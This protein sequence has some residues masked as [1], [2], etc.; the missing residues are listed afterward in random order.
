MALSVQVTGGG[1]TLFLNNSSGAATVG[2]AAT[3]AATSPFLLIDD[4]WTVQAPRP[5]VLW[6]GGPPLGN[7]SLPVTQSYDNVTESFAV[8]LVGSSAD[9]TAARKQQLEYTLNTALFAMPCML[10]VQPSGATSMMYAEIYS[11]VVQPTTNA[12]VNPVRGSSTITLQITITRSPFWTRASEQTLLTAQTYTDYNNGSGLNTRT[13]GSLSGD[14]IYE[15]QPLNVSMSGGDLATVGIKNI[16]M[17]TKKATNS[18]APRADA[19][20]TSSTTGVNVGGSVTALAATE[21]GVKQRITARVA[22]PTA[23]LQLRA[24]ATYGLSSNAPLYTG[25]WVTGGST[26]NA[27]YDL[28]GVSLPPSVRRLAPDGNVDVVVVIQAR[29][30]TGGAATGTLSWVEVIDYYTWA[31]LTTTSLPISTPNSVYSYNL[32]NAASALVIV[33]PPVATSGLAS[34]SGFGQ[35]VAVR[36]RLPV[37]LSGAQLWLCWDAAGVHTN[38]N[39]IAVTAAQAPLYR[40][41]RGAG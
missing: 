8:V 39:T 40:T 17:A 9:N 15:G 12:L 24:V 30:T 1:T 2:G 16:W 11:A 35:N 25:P 22:S 21:M 33:N 7:G 19:I 29:S 32:V 23:N 10:G 37:A 34:G 36:G 20:N 13:L 4:S 38:A 31:K 18:Y 14:M 6:S 26:T 5:Q 3:A 27:F 28:G 41:L